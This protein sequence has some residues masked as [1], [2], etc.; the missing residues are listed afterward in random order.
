MRVDTVLAGLLHALACFVDERL[1]DG[2]QVAGLAVDLELPL[3]ARAF[4]HDLPHVFDLA[5]AAQLVHHIVDELHELQR[6]IAH[7][8]FD[9]LAE[10]DQLAVDAPARPRAI[11][12]PRSARGGSGEIRD[13]VRGDDTA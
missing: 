4:G 10:V 1:H 12:F 2:A 8:H 5:T 6:E 9:A 13:S 3:G 7:R 11:C